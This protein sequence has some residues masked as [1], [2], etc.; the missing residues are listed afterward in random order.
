MLQLS[1]QCAKTWT[2]LTAVANKRSGS[3]D[4]NAPTLHSQSRNFLSMVIVIVFL[5]NVKIAFS[6]L[7]YSQWRIRGTKLGGTTSP[8]VCGASVSHNLPLTKVVTF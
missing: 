1:S 6:H 5:S 7:T 4:D 2:V 8:N 3:A